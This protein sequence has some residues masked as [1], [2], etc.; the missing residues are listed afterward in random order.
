M[1]DPL[2]SYILYMSYEQ[3]TDLLKNPTSFNHNYNSYSYVMI[4]I[5]ILYYN[6]LIFFFLSKKMHRY[7]CNLPSAV[8][9]IR[10]SPTTINI[11][12]F[13]LNAMLGF[14]FIFSNWQEK[15][16]PKTYFIIR[17]WMKWKRELEYLLCQVIP[18]VLKGVCLYL[19]I[20]TRKQTWDCL[21]GWNV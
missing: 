14:I 10:S 21:I 15:N 19:F 13:L 1:L 11:H 20:Y 4:R 3:F 9:V 8:F 12:M 16:K 5:K 18:I 17:N 7:F 6:F 2:V